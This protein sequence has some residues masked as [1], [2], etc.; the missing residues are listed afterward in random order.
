MATRMKKACGSSM[1]A[2]V[3]VQ[4]V[5]VVQGLQA[6]VV[7]L[8]V[9]LGLQRGAQ[10][11]QVELQQLLV[12]QLGLHALLDEAAGSSRRSARHL[13]LRHLAPST[14]RRWC[15]AAGVRWRRC[16]RVLLDQRARGQDGGL[17][18]L[19]H[20]HA[21]VQ[22]AHGLGQDGLGLDVGT[23]A[24]AGGFDQ[25]LAARAGPAARAGRRR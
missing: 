16:S 17:V 4:E 11:L 15:A 20:R 13:G 25:R 9:A 10:A 14:S 2:C 24:G 8:Q 21:V 1:R 12:Q 5:A 7:E 6:Q 19:V 3:D 23:Q 22:V 18:D